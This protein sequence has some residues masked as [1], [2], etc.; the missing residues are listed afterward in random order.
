M[1]V[2]KMIIDWYARRI[3]TKIVYYGPAMSGKT[4]TVKK[5]FSQLGY[6]N[7]IESLETSTGR[8]LFFDFGYIELERNGWKILLNIWTATGQDYYKATRPTILRGIDGI[9]FV[10]DAQRKMMDHNIRSWNELITFFDGELIN[11]I[12][13]VIAINKVDMEDTVDVETI[14]NTLGVTER[15]VKILKTV[16]IHGINVVETF[17]EIVTQIF[18]S[19]KKSFSKSIIKNE[20]IKISS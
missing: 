2:I 1:G 18:S 19:D 6:N 5:L 13:L 16:A 8:T 14:K 9:I 15:N 7:N 10:V 20:N 17:R 12:P 3:I 11:K 4:T